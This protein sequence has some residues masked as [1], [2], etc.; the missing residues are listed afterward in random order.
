MIW[1][2]WIICFLLA[3]PFIRSLW[4]RD[5]GKP[6][7]RSK[8]VILIISLLGPVALVMGVM[9][10]VSGND[11]KNEWLNRIGKFFDSIG[12]FLP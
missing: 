11:G 8:T 10:F 6:N 1:I 3:Y 7:G 2:I 12:R 4:I 5:F 9:I